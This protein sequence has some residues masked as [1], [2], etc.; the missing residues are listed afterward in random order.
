MAAWN[1]I[2]S[3]LVSSDLWHIVVTPI[4]YVYSNTRAI[5]FGTVTILT[6]KEFMD[7]YNYNYLKPVVR[8]PPK[9]IKGT[10]GSQATKASG[11]SSGKFEKPSL[12]KA[13]DVQKA[14]KE[15]AA[16]ISEV[17][18][19]TTGHICRYEAGENLH[20]EKLAPVEFVDGKDL[21]A[22][23][24]QR[25]VNILYL[26]NFPSIETRRTIFQEVLSLT[27]MDV[28]CKCKCP[29][30]ETSNLCICDQPQVGDAIE[31]CR[32]IS[33]YVCWA[34]VSQWE[35]VRCANICLSSENPEQSILNG[36]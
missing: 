9:D 16:P 1:V 25:C 33:G 28:N 32:S 3:K 14:A 4:K 2:K 20:D 36:G 8:R 17:M 11:V 30:C 10:I 31:T 5:V 35:H 24:L 7:D 27:A 13:R 18:K 15:E 19:E 26:V 12:N 23:V 22:N 29:K 34:L 6:V 21:D